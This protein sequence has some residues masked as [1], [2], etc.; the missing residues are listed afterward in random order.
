VQGILDVY[1]IFNS[2]PVLSNNLR[3]GPQWLQPT[4][5][6][7]ARMLKVGGRIEF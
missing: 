1:N 4:Q 5:I 3:Y 7:A 2:S 6:L